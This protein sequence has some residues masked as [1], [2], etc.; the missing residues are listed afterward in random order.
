MPVRLSIEQPPLVRLIFAWRLLR[1]SS[2]IAASTVI[3][4]LFTADVS[5]PEYEPD[6]SPNF[7]AAHVPE[8]DDAQSP[9]GIL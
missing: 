9:D 8:S 4:R 7:V 6:E 3:T 5:C 1:A 2:W